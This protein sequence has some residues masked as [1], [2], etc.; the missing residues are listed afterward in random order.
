MATTGLRDEDRL[1]GSSSYVIWKAKMSFWLDEYGPKLYVDNV[2]AVPYD[3][4]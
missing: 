3:A 4:N 1:D 2:V